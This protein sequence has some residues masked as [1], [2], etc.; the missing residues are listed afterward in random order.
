M[1]VYVTKQE[2]TKQ[3]EMKEQRLAC[4]A[5]ERYLVAVS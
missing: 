5:A 1:G 4:A 3:N 2:G